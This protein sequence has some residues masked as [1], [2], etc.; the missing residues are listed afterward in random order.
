[1]SHL[2]PCAFLLWAVLSALLAGFYFYH[3]WMYDRF[4]CINPFSGRQGAFQRVMTYSYLIALPVLLTFTIG[5]TV[6]KYSEGYAVIQGQIMAKPYELW[7]SQHQKAYRVFN[8]LWGVSWCLEAVSHTEEL[9]FWLYLLHAGPRPVPWFKSVY[10][11]LWISVT[12]CATIVILAVV[13]VTGDDPLKNEAYMQFTGS[14]VGLLITIGFLP[15]LY[16]FPSFIQAVRNEGGDMAAVV[17]LATFND[18]NIIRTVFRFLFLVPILMLSIDGMKPHTH[19]LNETAISLDFLPVL[20]GVSCIIQSALTLMIFFPRNVESE[21]ERW[22][23]S[24]PRSRART[25]RLFSQPRTETESVYDRERERERRKYLLTDSPVD[26]KKE[27]PTIPPGDAPPYSLHY[28]QSLSHRASPPVTYNVPLGMSYPMTVVTP[29]SK[30]GYAHLHDPPPAVV[31]PPPLI[32]PVQRPDSF[33]EASSP[34]PTELSEANMRVF[35]QSAP[36]INPLAMY[37]RS[38]LDF[39]DE[40]RGG[41]RGRTTAMEMGRF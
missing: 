40:P 10:F 3:L 12:T 31:A 22:L 4:R 2:S 41:K 11:W 36:K 39:D 9:C 27:L 7:T 29:D 8:F 19:G 25:P 1:M 30:K 5:F 33:P 18:L 28:D 16:V 37:F 20:S 24:R 14:L 34:R 15:V 23:K 26:K 21:T 17:R 35:S 38:P 6:I 13:G 32:T